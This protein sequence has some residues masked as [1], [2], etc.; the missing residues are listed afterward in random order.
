MTGWHESEMTTSFCAWTLIFAYSTLCEHVVGFNS[1][2][3][4]GILVPVVYQGRYL[5]QFQQMATAA[6]LAVHHINTRDSSLVG[7]AVNLFPKGFKLKYKIS[8][9]NFTTAGGVQ[10]I[11]NWRNQEGYSGFTTTCKSTTSINNSS[12]NASLGQYGTRQ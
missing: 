4:I 2:A 12:T 1:N 9:S 7:D 11:L 5:L 6:I 3:T 8:D 10:A